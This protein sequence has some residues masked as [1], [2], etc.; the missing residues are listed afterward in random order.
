[1]VVDVK[2]TDSLMVDEIFGPILPIIT[3]ETLGEA[4]NF[5]NTR[6]KPLA[7]YI[8]SDDSEVNASGLRPMRRIAPVPAALPPHSSL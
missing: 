1:M 5:V 8:F 7:L 4:I 2:E 3:V 6:E